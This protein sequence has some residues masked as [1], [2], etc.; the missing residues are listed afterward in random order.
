MY[1]VAM[2]TKETTWMTKRQAAARAGV[3]TRTIDRLLSAGKLTRYRRPG[4]RHIL[5]DA[6]Q[7]AAAMAPTPERIAS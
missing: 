4:T 5:I 3:S 1:G 6:H 7:L 2:K